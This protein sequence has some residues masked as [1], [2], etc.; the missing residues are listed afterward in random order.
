MTILTTFVTTFVI[1]ILP[2]AVARWEFKWV[3][4]E[5]TREPETR[6]IV[7]PCGLRLDGRCRETDFLGHSFHV[8]A[9]L[10]LVTLDP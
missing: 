8:L 7:F 3:V 10:D 2:R 5:T 9:G 4:A 1:T 6:N